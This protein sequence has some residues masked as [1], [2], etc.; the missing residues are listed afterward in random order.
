MEGHGSDDP[1]RDEM[2]VEILRYL[3]MHPSAKDTVKGIEKWW[4]SGRAGR[5]GKLSTQE[6]L[7]SL[8]SKGWLIARSSPQSEIIYSLNEDRLTEIVTFL[9]REP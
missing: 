1:P 5:G 3:V 8:V 4:L 9:K 7:N 6:G 2:I